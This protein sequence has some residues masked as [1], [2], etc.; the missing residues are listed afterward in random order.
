MG[1]CDRCG[2]VVDDDNLVRTSRDD[3]PGK[4][5]EWA[6]RA[7]AGISG[8]AFLCPSCQAEIRLLGVSVLMFG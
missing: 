1:S 3:A 8:D 7:V 2:A 4:V 5:P 6:G